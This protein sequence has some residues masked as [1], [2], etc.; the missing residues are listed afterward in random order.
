MSVHYRI[1]KHSLHQHTFCKKPGML[2]LCVRYFTVLLWLCVGYFFVTADLVAAESTFPASTEALYETIKK[3]N[4]DR[5]PK[6]FSAR[7]SAATVS[8]QIKNVPKEMIDFGKKPELHFHFKKNGAPRLVLNN[9]ADFYKNFFAPYEEI[10]ARS[11]LFL[12]IDGSSGKER[13]LQQ[14]SVSAPK[15]SE[16][17]A[18]ITIR[19][20]KG[21]PGD[22]AEYLFDDNWL[23]K[24]ALFYEANTQTSEVKFY[25]TRKNNYTLPK[26]ILVY[27]TGPQSLQLAAPQSSTTSQNAS[28]DHI[29]ITFSDYKF[30]PPPNGY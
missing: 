30:K 3:A 11:G 14:F 29:F 2:Q 25:F 12:G 27:L 24:Q 6:Y 16:E 20:R 19:E 22:Y 8:L 13:F 4:N 17:G 7:L 23:I 10:F 18:S 5:L 28:A 21:L 1:I 9:V 26:R 15:K